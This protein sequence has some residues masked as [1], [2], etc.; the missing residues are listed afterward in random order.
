MMHSGTATLTLSFKGSSDAS[1]F[2]ASASVKATALDGVLQPVT[3]QIAQGGTAI[4]NP[5]IVRLGG[6]ARYTIDVLPSSIPDSEIE[7]SVAEGVGNIVF[8]GGASNNKG[9]SVVVRGNAEGSFK[10]QVDK[11]AGQVPSPK[12]YIYGQV[13]PEAANPIHFYVLCD[14]LGHPCVSTNW[15]DN[16]VSNAN[17]NGR[18]LAMTFT[19]GSINYIRNHP[20]WLVIPTNSVE[21]VRLC[22]YTNNV[23]GIKVY[24]IQSFEP[25]DAL[26][27]TLNLLPFDEANGIIL[28]SNAKPVTLF[29]EILHACNLEDLYLTL[30]GNVPVS[31]EILGPLNWSGGDGTGYY[32]S[33]LTHRALIRRLMMY[34]HQNDNEAD[35]PLEDLNEPRVMVSG[36]LEAIRV[37][38]KSMETRTPRH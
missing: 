16:C 5:A 34:G 18:Q 19:R 13:E 11:I 25:S 7:W 2:T 10:L 32:P 15:I 37:S 35:V 30:I 1:N 36:K 14:A 21:T 31:K 6:R 38:R 3:R 28:A 22:S 8:N 23:G 4:V 17:H 20:E 29:H 27:A 33:D 9:R 24:C 26:G 12:P